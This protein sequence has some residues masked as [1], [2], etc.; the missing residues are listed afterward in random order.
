MKRPPRMNANRRLCWIFK[1]A[2]DFNQTI[3]NWDTSKVTDM[4]LMFCLAK[5]FNYSVA[6]WNID[7]VEDKRGMFKRAFAYKHP[8]PKKKKEV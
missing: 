5:K 2:I 6:D 8:K 3:D 1:G 7:K 4:N